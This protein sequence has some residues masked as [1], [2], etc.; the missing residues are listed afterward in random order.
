MVE[1]ILVFGILNI[2]LGYALAATLADPPLLG[3]APWKHWQTWKQHFSRIRPGS[4]VIAA[5]DTETVPLLVEEP[6]PLVEAFQ[7]EAPAAGKEYF[8]EN[9]EPAEVLP[10]VAVFEELPAAWLDLLETEQ[11]APRWFADGLTHALRVQLA[12]YRQHALA[13][14][15]RARLVLSQENAEAVEQLVAD[16]RFLHHE[17]LARLVEG[18]EMLHARRGRLGPAEEAGQR[19][20]SLLY[21]HAARMESI[22]RA[23]SDINFKTDVVLGCR[24]LLEELLALAAGIHLL[25]DDL[26]AALAAILRQQEQLAELPHEQR[27]DSLTGR[28]N[29]LGLEAA[30]RP[31]PGP[32]QAVLVAWDSFHLVNERLGT[33]AGDRVLRTLSQLLADLLEKFPASAE[34]VR[35]TGTRFLL[36]LDGISRDQAT[37]LAEQV[38]QSLEG[39]TLDCQGTSLDV[40]AR[41]G[42]T[43]VGVGDTLEMLLARLDQALDAAELAGRNRCAIA[44]GNETRLV[45]PHQVPVIARRV[46]IEQPE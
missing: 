7:L 32:R 13:A 11:L 20:E 17:W 26:A 4:P 41:M 28:L 18:A 38:R 23:I 39:V 22:D 8:V 1:L 15:A 30:F 10:P 44:E 33:R 40:S 34:I 19:L 5:E 3:F 9:E 27:L 35:L 14:E 21:D 29:R 36:L 25:R 42:I 46:E 45:A 24:R 43:S 12:A 31:P 37:S 6:P 16:F 2:V